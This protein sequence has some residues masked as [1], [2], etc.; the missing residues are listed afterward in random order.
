MLSLITLLLSLL[1][2]AAN[3]HILTFIL[4]PSFLIIYLIKKLKNSKNKKNKCIVK[5]TVIIEKLKVSN[6]SKTIFDVNIKLGVLGCVALCSSG[7]GGFSVSGALA[8]R[9]IRDEELFKKILQSIPADYSFIFIRNKSRGD[10]YLLCPRISSS[11]RS[12]DEAV[13]II[14]GILNSLATS[15]P[16][17]EVKILKGEELVSALLTASF[18][19]VE[20]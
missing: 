15:I 9:E 8:F 6:F 1:L 2:L 16:A 18:W 11:I 20:L 19:G 12:K 10:F 7:L 5:K 14:S 4:I 17:S 3:F 13:S